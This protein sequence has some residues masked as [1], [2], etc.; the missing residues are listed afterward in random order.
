MVNIFNEFI[1]SEAWAED[2]LIHW[3]HDTR[4]I[5]NCLKTFKGFIYSFIKL[6]ARIINRWTPQKF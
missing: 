4:G 1:V 5:F 2:Q 3:K 6:I